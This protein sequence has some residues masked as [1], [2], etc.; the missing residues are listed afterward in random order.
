MVDLKDPIGYDLTQLAVVNNTINE[1]QLVYKNMTDY[2]EAHPDGYIMPYLIITTNPSEDNRLPW[3][4]SRKLEDYARF[5]FVNTGLDRAYTTGELN[6]LAE[7]AGQTVEEY[8]K[9]H[10]P[11]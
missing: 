8:Y 10:C 4:K 3:S 9:H 5:E 2:N 11:S 1:S 6:Q 7:R